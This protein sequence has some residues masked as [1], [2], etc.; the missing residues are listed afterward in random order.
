M[1]V[2]VI[3]TYNV[4]KMEYL[5]GS[6]PTSGLFRPM[7]HKQ[8]QL[9]LKPLSINR[10]HWRS[11]LLHHMAPSVVRFIVYELGRSVALLV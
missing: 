4:Y 1:T 9:R 3:C 2:A 6:W 5:G 7:K 10:I 8:T 11:T